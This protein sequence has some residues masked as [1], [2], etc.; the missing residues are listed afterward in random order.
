M[1]VYETSDINEKVIL[2]AVE[3][4]RLI[5]A[6]VSLDELAQLVETS[7]GVSVGRIIQKREAVHPGHYLG[8]G[9][10]DELKELVVQ[11]GATGVVCDDELSGNQLRN[12]EEKLETKIM[13][14]TMVILD[15][16]ANCA[17]SAEGKAQVELA[18]LNYRASRLTGLGKSLSRLGGGI[19]TRGPGE[20]KL[21][22]DRRVIRGRIAALNAELKEIE[23]QRE[24]QRG[25]REKNNA[26]IISLV[27][28]TNAGKSSVMNLFTD[29]GVFASNRL[30]ATLD[31][32]TRRMRL[33]GGSEVLLTDTVG[34][35]QKLPHHLIKAF[36]ATLEELKYADILLHIVDVSSANRTEQMKTVYKTLADLKCGDKPVI[37]VFNKIDVAPHDGP[38][39][40]RAVKNALLSAK[41][42]DG[43]EKLLD[44]IEDVFQSLRKKI[45]VLI[46]YEKGQMVGLL[47][48][49]AEIISEEHT[50]NG[51][52][53][54]AYADDELAG[55]LG[56][57]III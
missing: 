28:Y 35:I 38:A 47:H 56:G 43:K 23:K 37:T 26:G 39:D 29:A 32:A 55:R 12:M 44:I 53:I 18:Q 31:T 42:G 22:T 20:T 3:D 36:R 46:P 41:T 9:K 5:D 45:T 30:F 40:P 34:F 2:A 7:G 16:F 6:D 8:K 25:K 14:R 13:D 21:E 15:I 1:P 50:E 51:V 11:N 54:E 24:V 57:Y 4:S 19:G 49:K 10:L 27:G 33:P 17:S 52:R 48:Q